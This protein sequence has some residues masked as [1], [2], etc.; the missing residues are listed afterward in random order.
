MYRGPL[1]LRNY[2][3]PEY[4]VQGQETTNH[5][6]IAYKAMSPEICP[7]VKRSQQYQLDTKANKY[8]YKQM[9]KF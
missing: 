1:L 7:I 5:L 8:R 6:D 2:L 9:S 4:T 3:L